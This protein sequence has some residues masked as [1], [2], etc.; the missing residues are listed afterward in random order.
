MFQ[1]ANLQWRSSK[2]FG[3]RRS[4]Q[5]LHPLDQPSRLSEL[6]RIGHPICGEVSVFESMAF[7]ESEEF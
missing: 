7:H 6:D 5:Y 2:G 3:S 4:L 1:I